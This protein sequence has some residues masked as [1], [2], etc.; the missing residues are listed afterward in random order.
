MSTKGSEPEPGISGA[1]SVSWTA[2]GQRFATEP[3]L[4]RLIELLALIPFVTTLIEVARS[5]RLQFLDYWWVL[6]RITFADGSVNL[7]NVRGLQNEHPL[8]VP[9]LLYWLDAKLF[10][11]DNRALGVLVVLVAGITVLALRAALPK[12]LSPV[13]RAS[14]VFGTS[15]LVFS[16]H[17]LHNYSRS[18][19]GI[20]WLGANLLVVAALLFAVR[21]KWVPAW[22]AALVACITYGTAFPVWPAL[23]LVATMNGESRWRRLAPLG[24]GAVVILTWLAVNE[25]GVAPGTQPANDL[26]TL[27]FRYLTV[28][29]HLWT[30]ENA[31]IAVFAA[32]ALLAVYAVLLGNQVARGPELRFWWALAVH[33]LL[34]CG[35][36]AMA[37]IDYGAEAGLFSRYTSISVLASLPALVIL[38]VVL[39]RRFRKHAYKLAIGAVAAGLLGYAL[40]ATTAG[41]IRAENQL[42]ALQGVAMRLNMANAFE[43]LNWPLPP[44]ASLTP[45]LRALDHY[46]FTEDFTLGC[47]GVELGS[48]L[49]QD[50]LIELP[51]PE[52][53]RSGELTGD[54]VRADVRTGASLFYGWVSEWRDPSRCVVLIDAEGKVTGGGVVQLRPAGLPPGLE[55]IPA[56]SG[57][58]VL[59]PTE[60]GDRI[61]VIRAGGAMLW[62]PATA[63]GT[64][65]K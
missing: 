37:R 29:G 62:L 40:G 36:I 61:V 50:K 2:L 22:A 59:G 28:L 18:M 53:H 16:L 34:A 46:P 21:G 27:I 39:H 49:D 30:A 55:H 51:T 8:I 19:S 63:S 11:G 32:V 54:V 41:I 31:A 48:K 60:R 33:A 20:A 26:G 52:E 25:R 35:M 23:A 58:A 43:T 3:V 56:G 10:D 4:A 64:G 6:A 38:L 17:G 24:M 44:S 57:F 47:G 42:H 1:R 14:M 12:A 7:P 65:E 5:P 45:R 13:V 9:S 15:L